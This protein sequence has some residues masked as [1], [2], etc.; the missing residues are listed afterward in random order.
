MEGWQRVDI[1]SLNKPRAKKIRGVDVTVYFGSDDMPVG[2][3]GEYDR[4]RGKFIIAFKYRAIDEAKRLVPF[5]SHVDLAVGQKSGRLLEV[6]LDVDA[7]NVEKVRL[8]QQAA[9]VLEEL[10]RPERAS[11]AGLNRLDNY[12]AASGA[13]KQVESRLFASAP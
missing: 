10:E 13:L 12:V 1:D 2:V 9:H 8:F 3:R 6:L 5:E 7:M 11:R 4:N